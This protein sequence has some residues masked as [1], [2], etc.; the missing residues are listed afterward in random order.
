MNA[1][2]SLLDRGVAFG[3]AHVRGGGELGRPCWHAAVQD[4][5]RITHTDLIS[6]AE[7]LIEQGLAAGT[8]SARAWS[9]SR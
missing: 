7:G 5:K 1:R 9:I 6:A 4:R 3:I 2:L 8:K